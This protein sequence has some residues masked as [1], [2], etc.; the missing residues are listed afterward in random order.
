MKVNYINSDYVDFEKIKVGEVFEYD[1]ICYLKVDR[2]NGFDV[3][4]NALVDCEEW[5]D[6]IL[7]DSELTIY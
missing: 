4:N 5:R 2:I 7:K 6:L 1:G 3:F